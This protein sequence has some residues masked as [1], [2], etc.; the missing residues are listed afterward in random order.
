MLPY[1]VPGGCHSQSITDSCLAHSDSLSTLTAGLAVLSHP[2]PFRFRLVRNSANLKIPLIRVATKTR[3]VWGM[4]FCMKRR[5]GRRSSQ[6][7][8]PA[9]RPSRPGLRPESSQPLCPPSHPP[10]LPGCDRR[11]HPRDRPEHSSNRSR[12]DHCQWSSCSRYC[13][14]IEICKYRIQ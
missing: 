9:R 1:L 3:C 4:L 13:L 11:P 14:P 6:R 7:A 2:G 10:Y 12:K 8:A 5:R